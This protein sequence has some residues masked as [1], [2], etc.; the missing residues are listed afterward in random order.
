MKKTLFILMIVLSYFS[1]KIKQ[2]NEKNIMPKSGEPYV[3]E[4]KREIDST[5]FSCETKQ[6]YYKDVMPK[7]GE[8]YTHDYK[9]DIDS[10]CHHNSAFVGNY[11]GRLGEDYKAFLPSYYTNREGIGIGIILE[12]YSDG[13]SHLREYF[14]LYGSNC[15]GEWCSRDD[16][17]Y[18]TCN[19]NP[20]ITDT[21]VYLLSSGGFIYGDIEI[22]VLNKKRLKL[23]DGTVLY[24][25]KE[26]IGE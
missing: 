17:I 23:K 14:D 25:T 7:Y 12:L 4:H 15:Y 2:F 18:I 10:T 26:K 20:E 16:M 3:L 22:K 21:A 8:G 11:I 13:T 5:C 6:F 19:Q 24:R 9:Q 1:C